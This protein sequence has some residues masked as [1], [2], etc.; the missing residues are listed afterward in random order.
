MDGEDRSIKRSRMFTPPA[1]GGARSTDPA[2][3]NLSGADQAPAV[4]Q[5]NPILFYPS[6]TKEQMNHENAVFRKIIE[7][8]QQTAIKYAEV[9]NEQYKEAAQRYSNYAK[10]VCR[11]EVRQTE[12]MAHNQMSSSLNMLKTIAGHEIAQNRDALAAE[13]NVHIQKQKMEIVEEAKQFLTA[14]T[15][16]AQ[17][18]FQ[19]HNQVATEEFRVYDQKTQMQQEQLSEM[20]T[21][22]YTE[23]QSMRSICGNANALRA[24]LKSIQIKEELTASRIKISYF[25]TSNAKEENIHLEQKLKALVDEH[26]AELQDRDEQIDI[27]QSDMRRR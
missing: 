20:W 4:R 24:E 17:R 5:S 9:R 16:N 1:K 15:Y 18:I 26:Q 27:M 8:T 12:E 13:A 2:L 14:Y 23:G 22:L 11:F 3:R 21:E 10:D 7:E 6:P 25:E 19:E